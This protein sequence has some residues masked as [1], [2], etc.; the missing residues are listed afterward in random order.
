MTTT[1]DQLTGR[2]ATL[3]KALAHPLRF[4]IMTVLSDREASPKELSEEFGIDLKRVCEQVDILERNYGL[5]QLVDTDRRQGGVQHFYRAIARSYIGTP[6]SRS[7]SAGEREAI[8]DAIT[9]QMLA[10]LLRAIESKAMD[11][12]VDRVLIRLPLVLDDEG[13][14][15]A[16]ESAIRHMEELM[17]IQ[18]R[19][20]ERRSETGEPGVNAATATSIF[21]MPD[22]A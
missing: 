9:Q 5:I 11:S 12:R 14:Q 22:S 20:A 18:A 17:E 3:L 16:D 2:G 19:S 15:E 6:E 10:D 7:L 8:S 1:T 4:R 21:P 13:F